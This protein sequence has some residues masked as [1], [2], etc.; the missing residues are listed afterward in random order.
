ML[1]S[2]HQFYKLAFACVAW[3]AL[4]FSVLAQE[5]PKLPAPTNTQTETSE[6]HV[7]PTPG[8]MTY[9]LQECLQIALSRNPSIIAAHHSLRATEVGVHALNNLRPITERLSPDIPFRRQQAQRGITVAQA[10]VLKAE[11]ETTYDVTSLYY[12]YVYAFQQELTVIDVL[13]QMDI[14]Y[15]TAEEIVKSGGGG[16]KVTQFTLYELQTLIRGI[17]ALKSK[18]EFGRK[19]S[20]EALKEALSLDYELDFTPRDTQLPVLEGS[21][22][23]TQVIDWAIQRRP[24]LMQAAAAV[25]VFRLEICAQDQ[26]TLRQQ[27]ATFAAGSDLHSKVVPAAVRNGEY[28]P[29]AITPEMPSSLVGRREDRVA[30]AAALS[31]QQDEVYRKAVNLVRLEAS[32]AYL[33]YE[34]ATQRMRDAKKHLESSQRQ[35]EDARAAAV[36]RQDPE[37]LVNNEAL[38]G[39]ALADYVESVYEH[40]KILAKLQRVTGG[41]V[42]PNFSSGIPTSQTIKEPEELK[43]PTNGSGPAK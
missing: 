31:L 34:A 7:R 33:E 26:I 20:L 11:Q 12:T 1:G 3:G 17:R 42:T 41:G 40:L 39:R 28:K 23:R 27:V 6:E 37:L 38:A 8:A 10:A 29:G 19:K 32:I 30:R 9:N 4:C 18:A 2:A 5:T 21:I 16:K 13:E 36:A 22:T 35:A 25:D 15:K 24:E 14:Y 43:K